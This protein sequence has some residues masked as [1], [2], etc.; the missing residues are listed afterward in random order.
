MS[1]VHHRKVMLEVTGTTDEDFPGIPMG[2]SSPW[3]KRLRVLA[4][5][6]KVDDWAAYAGPENWLAVD[7]QEH[8]MK[9]A[10]HVAA[11]IFP[12]LDAERYRP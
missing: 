5:K 11:G 6:G 10:P 4:V 3:G 2:M 9:L 12:V 7:V 8:G 1:L